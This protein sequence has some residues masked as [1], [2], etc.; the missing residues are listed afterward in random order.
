MNNYC[1]YVRMYLVSAPQV[2]VVAFS[3][4]VSAYCPSMLEHLWGVGKDL[5]LLT[6]KEII[7]VYSL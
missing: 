7:D 4:L 5:I 6:Y 2:L 1:T 3:Y